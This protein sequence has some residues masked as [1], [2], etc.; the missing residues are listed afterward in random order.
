MQALDKNQDGFIT[1]EEFAKMNKMMS[2]KQVDSY[3]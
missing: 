1:K 2:P 3:L